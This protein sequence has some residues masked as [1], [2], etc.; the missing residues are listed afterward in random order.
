[1]RRHRWRLV[2]PRWLYDRIDGRDQRL[3]LFAET[4]MLQGR[5]FET[6]LVMPG[7]ATPT[8]AHAEHYRNDQQTQRGDTQPDGERQTNEVLPAAQSVAHDSQSHVFL[9]FAAR[10]LRVANVVTLVGGHRIDN[11]QVQPFVTR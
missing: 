10:T 2:T 7:A 4:V 1:V 11:S 9:G 8:V 5:R 6:L 3:L